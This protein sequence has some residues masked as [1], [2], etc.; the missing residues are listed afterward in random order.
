M[1]NETV[2]ANIVTVSD[3]VS[4]TISPAFVEGSQMLG[5]LAQ[6]SQQFAPNTNTIKFKKN[7]YLTAATVGEL[8]PTSNSQYAQTSVSV[9]AEKKAVNTK[10]SVEAVRFTGLQPSQIAP[11]QGDAFARLFDS[12]VKTL[13]T[14]FTN[15]VTATSIVTKDDLIEASYVVRNATLGASSNKLLVVLSDKQIKDLQKELSS[16]GASAFASGVIDLGLLGQ[17]QPRNN[18]YSFLG[19]DILRSSG[20]PTSGSD[21]VGLVFDPALAF[22]VGLDGVSGFR[23]EIKMPDETEGS[24]NIWS[25]AFWKIAELN[26]GAG[27]KILSDS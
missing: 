16:T 17:V 25:Y 11:L 22:A 13:F 7:G 18:V 14:G 12:E 9:V 26:D 6:N 15:S 24:Y 20:L 5:V 23:T 3:I 19:M 21:T 10:L 2:L 4:A 1:A 8:S 27:C